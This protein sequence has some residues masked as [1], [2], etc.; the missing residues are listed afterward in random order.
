[1]LISI[2]YNIWSWL[3]EKMFSVTGSPQSVTD[4]MDFAVFQRN[5]VDSNV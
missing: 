1:M 5:F 3:F 2:N 4:A